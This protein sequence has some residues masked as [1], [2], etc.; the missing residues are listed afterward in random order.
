MNSRRLPKVRKLRTHI[1]SFSSQ[2]M[3]EAAEGCFDALAS[4]NHTSS[5]WYRHNRIPVALTPP[6]KGKKENRV[7]APP[8]G[9]IAIDQLYPMPP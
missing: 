1:S 6:K 7:L 4:R 9:H 3:S 8:V 5:P 2:M